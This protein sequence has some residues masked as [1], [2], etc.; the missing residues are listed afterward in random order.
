MRREAHQ[1]IEMLTSRV[2]T[3]NQELKIQLANA[4]DREN[5]FQEDL[6]IRLEQ[7]RELES[8]GEE[9]FSHFVQ[10][11]E[12]YMYRISDLQIQ[13]EQISASRKQL[14]DSHDEQNTQLQRVIES[15]QDRIQDLY[16][17]KEIELERQ[18]LHLTQEHDESISRLRA[19][20][21][22]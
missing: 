19:A 18:R 20:H 7:V 12:S 15:L 17:A 10:T 2:E 1:R 9:M 3:Q 5:A 14:A 11:T 21:E 6:R 13:V 4:V 22:R 8:A 16:E